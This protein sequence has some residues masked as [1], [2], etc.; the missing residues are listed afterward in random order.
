MLAVN[1]VDLG[2]F[3]SLPDMYQILVAILVTNSLNLDLD[4]EQIIFMQ[5][6]S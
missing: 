5:D 1:K 4:L 6:K 2:D 3:D